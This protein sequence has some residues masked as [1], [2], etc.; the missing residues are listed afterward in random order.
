V[1]NVR[2]ATEYDILDVIRQL[3]VALRELQV[4]LTP[5]FG[6]HLLGPGI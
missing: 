4:K 6:P 5:E 2:L 1:E 3:E